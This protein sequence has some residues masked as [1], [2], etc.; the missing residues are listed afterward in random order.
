[1]WTGRLVVTCELP[2]QEEWLFEI[3]ACQRRQCGMGLC[4]AA[5]KS[6]N[7]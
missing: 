6:F 2:V 4:M 5:Y 7:L 1:M 3:G